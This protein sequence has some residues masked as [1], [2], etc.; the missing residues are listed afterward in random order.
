[1][2]WVPAAAETQSLAWELPYAIGAAIKKKKKKKKV[3]IPLIIIPFSS[4]VCL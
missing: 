2:A 4:S 1:M 3:V